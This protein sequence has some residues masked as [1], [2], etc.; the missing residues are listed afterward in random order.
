MKKNKDRK[1]RW[2]FCFFLV[3]ENDIL[4][5]LSFSRKMQTSI[6][7]KQTIIIKMLINQ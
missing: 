7:Y 1:N 2:L 3:S 5:Y 6:S 4:F